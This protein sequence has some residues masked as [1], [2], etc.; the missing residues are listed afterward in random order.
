MRKIM[1]KIGSIL[2]LLTMLV[3]TCL[4][5]LPGSTDAANQ[6]PVAVA[7]P[8]YQ[9]IYVGDEAWFN[10]NGSYDPDGWIIDY[11]WD[12]GDGNYSKGFQVTHIYSTAG[13]YVVWLTVT[14]NENETG[15]DYA[16]VTVLSAPAND[17]PVADAEPDYQTV[18]VGDDAWFDGNLSYD[19]DGY[20]VSYDWDFGDGNVGSGIYVT[21]S[22]SAAGFYNVTL[23]VT[24]DD[25]ATDSDTVFVE[26]LSGNVTNDPPVADAEPNHQTVDVGDDAWFDGNLSYDPDGYIV[27]YD[28]EFGDGGTGTGIYVTHSY[29]APGFY[30]VTLTVTDDDGAT[31]TD[32]VTV[33]VTAVPPPNQPPVA[34]AG[35]DDSVDEDTPYFFD[36]SGSYDPDGTIVDYS[37][38]FGDGNFGSGETPT[39]IYDTPGLYF[40]NL[41]VTDDD[42]ATDTDTCMITVL[43]TYPTPPTDLWALLVTGSLSDVKLEWTASED[44]GAGSD[45]VAGY[46]VYKSINGVNGPYNFEAWITALKIPGHTYEWTDFGV[47]D[48]DWNNYFYIVRAKDTSNNEEQNENR[49]GKF[50]SY[51]EEDW[52]LVSVPLVQKDTAKEVVLQTIDPNYDAVRGYHAGYSRPWLNW[53]R[54]KPNQMNDE[55]EI[56]HREGYYIYMKSAD[57][58]VTAGRVAVQ[59]E[60]PLKAGWNLVGYPCLTKRTRNDALSSIDGSYNKVL[61]CNASVKKLVE[62]GPNDL[63][64]PGKAYWIHATEVCTWTIGN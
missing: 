50:V 49:V 54:N 47:G 18:D 2:M 8:K 7:N 31:D 10:A 40:V 55:I 58:L 46:T 11:A 26:V 56:N 63:M 24:D 33:N 34:D 23:T 36:G 16:N 52:N 37:W 21:H 51:L 48:G 57:H 44:D 20:I 4:V 25:G 1:K 3:T 42:S 38:E 59:T 35:P 28:W 45:D 9:E 27:S 32:T 61:Y 17:P 29:T 13:S 5:M 41:T 12:F 60:I 30:Y 14:D 22:Y 53:H 15:T 64:M 6:P 43:P 19:P 62:L 39:H